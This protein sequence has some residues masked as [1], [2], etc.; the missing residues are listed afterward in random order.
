MYITLQSVK[1]NLGFKG[2]EANDLIIGIPLIILFLVLFCLLEYHLIALAQLLIS[3][4]L[5]L[6]VNVSQKNRMYKVLILVIKYLLR[7][8]EYIFH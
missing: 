6:P 5:L 7:E 4:F 2:L 1:K 8:K 3:I